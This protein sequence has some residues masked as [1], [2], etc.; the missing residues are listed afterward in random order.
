[1]TIL[2]TG[3]GKG[4]GAALAEYYL[5]NGHKVYGISRHKNKIFDTYPAYRFLSQDL[6]DFD[7]MALTIPD[8]LREAGQLDIAILNA[9]VLSEIADMKDTN[10]KDIKDVMDI[11]VWSNKILIDLMFSNLK[12]IKQIVAISS[13]AAVSGN[14][15]WNSYSLSKA[16]LNM[17]I[18]LYA[19]E[20]PDTHFSAIAPGLIDTGMQ[21]H[22]SSLKYDGRFP[23]IESLKKARGTSQMPKPDAAAEKLAKVIEKS[24]Q[25]ESGV[26]LDIREMAV[27]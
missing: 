14:R 21:E 5:K 19:G 15:G 18:Q 11:N 25:E 8:F 20:E 16:A 27:D 4:L 9:G 3:T 22:I 7:E 24:I 6:S 26:F 17:L 12:Q 13:G 10:L 2:I 23:T 1:M